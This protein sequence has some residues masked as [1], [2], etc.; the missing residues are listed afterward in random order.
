[1]G[2]DDRWSIALQQEL[3]DAINRLEYDSYGVGWLKA[4]PYPNAQLLSRYQ[5][6]DPCSGHSAQEIISIFIEEELIMNIPEHAEYS[7]LWSTTWFESSIE[8]AHSLVDEIVSRSQASLQESA[9]SN[10]E[11]SAAAGLS[12]D[13]DEEEVDYQL[14]RDWFLN[15]LFNPETAIFLSNVD[16]KHASPPKYPAI[17]S[18]DTHII[19]IFWIN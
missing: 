15:R 6:S 13:T 17:V 18:M 2:Y 11:Y 14:L 5:P 1:M 12:D 9:A 8:Q 19:A 4:L 3:C 16:P 7:R 10:Q